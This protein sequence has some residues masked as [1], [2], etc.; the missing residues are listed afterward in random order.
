MRLKA[1]RARMTHLNR[2]VLNPARGFVVNRL[3]LLGIIKHRG[4]RSGQQYVTPV[5][6]VRFDECFLVPLTYGMRV[7]WFRN[8]R[9]AQ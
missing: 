6:V 3:G 5:V 1:V 8:L 9:S 7:D 4:R 2:R